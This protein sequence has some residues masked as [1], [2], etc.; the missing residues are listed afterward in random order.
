MQVTGPCQSARR[1]S[2]KSGRSHVL[3][4]LLPPHCAYAPALPPEV[5][6][7]GDTEEEIREVVVNRV[8]DERLAVGL[9][10]V[11]DVIVL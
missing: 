8:I 4:S 9:P 2:L 11:V 6:L 10:N 1:V 3:R 7:A 5:E